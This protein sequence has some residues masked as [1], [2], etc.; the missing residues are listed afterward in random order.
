MGILAPLMLL[1]GLAVSVP[2]VLHFFYKARHRPLPWAAMEF[3][4]QSIEQTSRRLKFQELILLA[5]RCLALILL[6]LALARFSFSAGARSGRGESVAAVFVFDTTYSMGAKDQDRNRLDRAKEAALSIIDSLPRN[7][8]VQVYTCTDRAAQLPFTPTNLD[9]ARNIVRG[10]ELTSLTGDILPG[11][12]EGDAA[13]DR[14]EGT[15]KELYIF[16]DLQKNGWERQAAALKEKAKEIQK[17]A[18]LIIVRCGNPERPVNNVLVSDI[19]FP[20]GIPHTNTRLPFTVL[21]KNTGK[22]P[23]LNVSV[24]LEV[25]G[26]LQNIDSGLAPRIEPNH[27]FPVTL[28]G[29]LSKAGTS[30]LTAKI[31]EGAKDALPGGPAA[32]S[33]PDDLPGDN[34]F[35]KLILVRD[36]VRVLLVD[37][38]RDPR[39]PKDSAGHFIKNALVPV[40][41]IN[42]P[43]YFIR[44]TDVTPNEA[45]P[46]LLNDADLCI[47]TNAPASDRDRPGIPGLSQAFV[48]RLAKF[49]AEG[50]GLLIGAGELTMPKGYNEVFHPLGLLPFELTAAE[51]T[52]PETPFKPAPD[53]TE[54][55]SFLSRL[56]EEPYATVTADA[57]VWTFLGTNEASAAN[58]GHVMLRLDNGRPLLT[59]KALGD[60]EVLFLH[61]SLDSRWTNWPSKAGSYLSIVQ[62]MLSH[63]TGR[64]PP[65]TNRTAGEAFSWSPPEANRVVDLMRPNKSRTKLGKA[66][67]AADGGGKPSVTA[68]DAFV[69]GVY[70]MGYED[71]SALTGP[72]FAVNADQRESYDLASMTDDAIAGAIGF[73]PIMVTAG[74]EADSLVGNERDRRELTVY[75]LMLLFLVAGVETGWAWYCGRAK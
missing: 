13:L 1:G 73:K 57:D 55:P 74:N 19:T 52:K 20:G 70:R 43:D 38:N 28:T 32:V 29:L 10:I 61:T 27:T 17:R 71:E 26:Q 72:R 65:G 50:H 23:V 56:R 9:Q 36:R 47:L 30:L 21:L 15:N 39:D 42:R 18:T 44:V 34:R 12:V 2:L 14:A 66:V 22:N 41:E 51:T 46:A 40:P 6:A 45:V 49:V 4:R 58:S 60:G 62:M 53:T 35:D 68:T 63:F 67:V 69:A 64:V 48:D 16:S 3:L 11:M 54:T 31:G 59:A 8:S 37:G 75:L 7:S 25:D 33:T 5:L 24:T